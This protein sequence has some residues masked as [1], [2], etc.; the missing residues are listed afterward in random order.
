MSSGCDDTSVN[1]FQLKLLVLVFILNMNVSVSLADFGN[2][3]ILIFY[4][5]IFMNHDINML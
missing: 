4:S 1:E 2:L 5:H 3:L